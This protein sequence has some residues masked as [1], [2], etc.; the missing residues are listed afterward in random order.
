MQGRKGKSGK[1]LSKVREGFLSVLMLQILYRFSFCILEMYSWGEI[2]SQMELS[3][4]G[5]ESDVRTSNSKNGQYNFELCL[6][7]AG[8]GFCLPE[9]HSFQWHPFYYPEK[10]MKAEGIQRNRQKRIRAPEGRNW[11]LNTGILKERKQQA[12]VIYG[13]TILRISWGALALFFKMGIC[14]DQSKQYFYVKVSERP[15]GLQKDRTA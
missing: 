8:A 6:S 15:R 14:W 2:T 11:I 7:L 3:F 1:H 5:L 9:F 12:Y 13:D 4:R 10:F